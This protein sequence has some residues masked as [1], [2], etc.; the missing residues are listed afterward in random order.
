MP[1]AT[2]ESREKASFTVE[3]MTCANCVVRV[4]KALRRQGGVSEASVNLATSRADVIF[5]ATR[6]R[7]E[8]IFATV[9]KAG[10][11]PVALR[12]TGDDSEVQEL[13]Q[14]TILA[15]LFGLPLL[16]LA[17]GPML[18]PG[19][20]GLVMGVFGTMD[21]YHLVQLLL[22][23][24]VVF[25]P[26]RRF[27][28]HG[29]KAYRAMS[30][31]MNSL[32]MSGTL[33]AYGYSAAVTLVPGAFPADLRSVYFE[34]A[35]VVITLVLLGK[36]LE[37]R[38]KGRSGEAIRK[39]LALAPPRAHVMR[40]GREMDIEASSILIG[41]L[42]DV[43]PGERLPVDG[44]ILS[45]E[46]WVDESMLTGEPH[47]VHKGTGNQATGGTLNGE[48]YL[49]LRANR[50][51]S[52]TVLARIVRLVQEAQASRPPI[53]DLADRVVAWFTP[54]V[55]GLALIS[56][57]IWL[58]LGPNFPTA[59]IHAVSVLVI[60][61]PC[62]MGLATPTAVLVATGRAAELGVLFRKGAAL[63]ALAQVQR[64]AFDKTGTLTQGHP[65]VTSFSVASGESVK[66]ILALAA[67][68]EGRSAHP[69]AR[70]L[71]EHARSEGVSI[72]KV[73]AF[74]SHSGYGVEGQ[75]KGRQVWV[76]SPRFLA[77]RGIDVSRMASEIN[78]AN[79][80]GAAIALV[81]VEGAL[82]AVA[83]ITDA[84]KP[85]AAEIIAALKVLGIESLLV[86]GD[87]E[88]AALT[89]AKAVGIHQVRAEVLPEEKAKVVAEE[90]AQGRGLLFVGDGVNDAPALAAADI[91]LAVGG[92]TEIAIEAGDCVLL[93]GD[94]RGVVR[95]V[96]LSRAAMQTIRRNLFWAFFYNA[97]LIPVAAGLLE[98][99]GGPGLHPVFAAG[100]MG[101]SS[102]LVVQGSLRLKRFKPSI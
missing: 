94:L 22:A 6:L 83:S 101:L 81:V 93:S 55:L 51:G 79:D 50:V 67:A 32:V 86:T 8:D 44:E 100:A 23:T 84:L 52:D 88:N 65:R 24:P 74:Q 36:Y 27:L 10:Y 15:C 2:V 73:E 37:Q 4:E 56:F 89:V 41:D 97:L 76:G 85:H 9:R 30:P 99:F 21:N 87:R 17:M 20:M 60:A 26:G 13:R 45:G 18:F 12:E 46:S 16:L 28:I 43:R 58:W 39:L 63:Q 42:V 66:E 92:G 40:D 31:D 48:G 91:G 82:V 7:T 90:Q 49:T 102:L 68:V 5:D 19:G 14:A 71:A 80:E 70:A 53:Q 3:G 35:A 1:S 98:P 34:S 75:V 64:A 69:L 96:E 77:E 59:L 29:F 38:G 61:C 57:A 72:P 54:V 11:T 62:A 25:G 78:K 33:A 95:A 47:P